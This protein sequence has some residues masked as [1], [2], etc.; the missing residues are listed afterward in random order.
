MELVIVLN[1]FVF[2]LSILIFLYTSIVFVFSFSFSILLDIFIFLRYIFV[3]LSK[4]LKSE[5]K[6]FFMILLSNKL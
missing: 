5:E 3:G 6:L 4:N 1:R 2:L